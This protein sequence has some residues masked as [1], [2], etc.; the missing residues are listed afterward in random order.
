MEIT[1]SV[2]PEEVVAKIMMAS[3]DPD[4]EAT[5]GVAPSEHA[6][7]AA[8]AGPASAPRSAPAAAPAAPP[9]SPASQAQQAQQLA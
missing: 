2:T 7:A 3:R 4:L 8:G 6:Q 9:P 1:P 5:G